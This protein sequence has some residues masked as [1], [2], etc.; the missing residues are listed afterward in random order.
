MKCKNCKSKIKPN[1]NFCP[2]CGKEIKPKKILIKKTQALIACVCCVVLIVSGTIGGLYFYKSNN[3]I[4]DSD[5]NYI[6]LEPGFTD[7]KI[8]DEKSALKAIS[9]VAD[10]IGIENVDDELKIISTNTVDGD[11]YYRFQQY[12]NDIPVYGNSLV[13]SADKDGNAT[14]LTSNYI[15]INKNISNVPK[16]TI[17]DINESVTEYF[18]DENIVIEDINDNKLIYYIKDNNTLNLSYEILI[19]ELGYSIILDAN[20]AKIIEAFPVYVNESVDCRYNDNIIKGIKTNLG[21][22]LVGDE[23]RGIYIFTANHGDC[24]HRNSNGELLLNKNAALPMLSDDN[25]FGNENDAYSNEEYG[26][27]INLLTCLQ[28]ISDYYKSIDNNLNVSSIGVVND[29]FTSENGY[30]AMGG[31]SEWSEI[32]SYNFNYHSEKS[33]NLF[34]GSDLSTD[35]YN[36]I[37]T[38]AHEYTHG[39]TDSQINWLYDGNRQSGALSEAYSDI[40]GEILESKIQENEP[41]WIHGKRDSVNPNSNSEIYPYPSTLIDLENAKTCETSEGQTLYFVESEDSGTDYAHF[42]CTIISHSAYLMWNGIDGSENKKIDCTTLAKLWYNSLFLMQSNATFSQCRN[43]VELSARIMM[44]NNELNMEQ[45]LCVINAF[46]EVGIEKATISYKYRVKNDFN[47]KVLGSKKTGNTKFNL[48]IYKIPKSPFDL[49]FDINEKERLIS[50]EENLT[51][52]KNIHLDDGVY[53]LIISPVETNYG[54][55]QPIS[56]QICVDEKYSNAR[57]EVTVYTEFDD[58]TTVELNINKSNIMLSSLLGKTLD[59]AIKICG[60]DYEDIDNESNTKE[61]NLGGCGPINGVVYDNDNFKGVLG[62]YKDNKYFDSNEISYILTSKKKQCCVKI[63]DIFS[64]DNTYAQL[65]EFGLN[66]AIIEDELSIYYFTQYQNT[67]YIIT[68]MWEENPNNS[69]VADWV[70]ISS[71]PKESLIDNSEIINNNNTDS[72]DAGQFYGNQTAEQLRKSVIGSWGALGSIAPEYNFID[73]ENCSGENPWQ[74]SGNYSI[75]DNKTLTISWSGKSESEIYIWS[76]ESWDEFY[77]H[78]KHDVNFWYMTDDGILI[79]NGKE[80]YRDGVDD[81]TYNSNGD[82]MAIISGIWISD[83]GYKEYQITSDGTWTESTVVISGGTLINRTKLD[84]GKV[85]IIDDTTAK[86]WQETNSLSQIPGASEL[87]YD[88]K[89]DKISVG[90]INNT[91][92]R[93]KYK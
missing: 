93:A 10:V 11:T 56:I 36:N 68:Y 39:I 29:N 86:L 48:S 42:A 26:I 58:L 24:F 87:I 63:D 4:D 54:Y 55:A 40:F 65:L 8:T 60:S 5:S 67:E 44:K 34:I 13:I 84:N 83:K 9:S 30:G 70:N 71:V 69:D 52:N 47:L 21:Q 7:I 33:N 14:A 23:V 57:D 82:L 37:D 17:E 77:S 15:N 41:D 78:H 3:T 2:K 88:S 62:L 49:E 85:E 28:K 80:K 76:S 20:N 38:V 22:Y 91:F 45:Y 92:T 81:F 27:G 46:N 25:I 74:S 12:Y 31:Y 50:E 89:N 6:S 72:N 59:D 18:D 43:A 61:Y 16:A 53:K 66:K 1:Q 51:D 90:G 73:S 35:I 79:L 32:T 64:T 19:D 75:S